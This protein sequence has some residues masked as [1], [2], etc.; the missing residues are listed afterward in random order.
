M[1]EAKAKAARIRKA[2]LAETKARREEVRRTGPTGRIA[3]LEVGQSL[4]LVGYTKTT[5]VSSAI[6]NAYIKTGGRYTSAL[7]SDLLTGETVMGVTVTRT[8]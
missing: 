5:E 2:I 1:A 8:M 6:R 3:A 4:T 7:A